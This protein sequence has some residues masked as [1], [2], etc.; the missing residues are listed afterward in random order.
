[1]KPGRGGSGR[2]ENQMTGIDESNPQD[3]GEKIREAEYLGAR[4]GTGSPSGRG[5]GSAEIE[6]TGT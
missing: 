6:S 3:L 2:D 5:E 1:M 4:T